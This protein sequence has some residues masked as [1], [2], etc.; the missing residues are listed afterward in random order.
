MSHLP[1]SLFVHLA[2]IGLVIVAGTS[3]RSSRSSQAPA[4]YPPVVSSDFGGMRNVSVAG[5]IWLGA[6]P[7][8]EDLELARRRGICQVIDLTRSDEEKPTGV[9]SICER[10]ELE[11]IDAD[12][13]DAPLP[14]PE[15]VDLVL[16]CLAADELAPTLMFDG[17]GGRCAIY[18]AIH[19]IIKWQVPLEEALMEARRAGMKPGEPEQFVREQVERITGESTSLAES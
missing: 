11:Y 18:L 3:C 17:T 7:S 6:K 14:T 2:A 12:L 15:S 16:E 5:P 4:A 10:L 8:E 1:S 13:P 9:A 19:R